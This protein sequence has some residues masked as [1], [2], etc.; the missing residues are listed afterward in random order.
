MLNVCVLKH[1]NKLLWIFVHNTDSSCW[2]AEAEV[3][4]IP[5]LPQNDAV[6][7]SCKSLTTRYDLK[8]QDC[9]KMMPLEEMPPGG[10]SYKKCL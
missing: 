3:I 6:S 4:L 8:R 2:R 9:K 5:I 1:E 7:Q 10:E